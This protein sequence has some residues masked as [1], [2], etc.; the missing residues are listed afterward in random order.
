MSRARGG[1]RRP[2]RRGARVVALAARAFAERDDE[3]H[4]LD[5]RRTLAPDWFQRPETVGYAAYVDRFAGDLRGVADRVGYLERLGVTYLHLLPLL[6]PRPGDN[7]GGYAVM[8]YRSVREDLGTME[9]LRDLSGTLRA[10][11]ISLCLDLVLNHVAAEHEWAV[12]ARAGEQRYRDYFHIE[13][14]R[15]AVDAWEATLPDV[16]PD[17]APGSFTW[18]DEVGAGSGR[19]S[20]AGSGT[21]TGPTRTSSASTPTSSSTWRTTAWRRSGSTRSRSSGNASARRARTSRRCTRS[22]RPCAP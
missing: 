9:D 19:R 2:G 20:T 22:P 18:D 8:D 21:S 7:D 16:F 4:A 6:R 11:G 1:V 12:R 5:L 14:D 10:H 3:L 13:A 15:A 17:F